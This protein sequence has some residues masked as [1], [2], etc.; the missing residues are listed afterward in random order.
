[1]A[2]QV[3]G[4]TVIDNSR[5]LLN[6]SSIRAPRL[7][8]AP[9]SPSVGDMYQNTSDDALYIYRNGAWELITAPPFTDVYFN[10]ITGTAS[11][12]IPTVSIGGGWTHAGT[13][14]DA[15][16]FS[17]SG[18]GDYEL[19]AMSFGP[20]QG[21]VSSP[22]ANY[23]VTSGSSTGGTILASGTVS[24]PTNNANGFNFITLTTAPLLVRG[25]S[26]TIAFDLISS[27]NTGNSN[28]NNVNSSYGNMTY[29][30]TTFNG[31]GAFGTSNGTSSTNGQFPVIH[32]GI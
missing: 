6:L 2:I 19:R 27:T 1:M 14:C 8:S 32:L 24:V 25:N 16:T 3:N 23:Q 30:S 10:R 21:G 15:I 28:A 12:S 22:T 11:T 4:T 18:S 29:S 7:S 26:Y 13:N 20:W 17:L 31:S 5:N 9:S